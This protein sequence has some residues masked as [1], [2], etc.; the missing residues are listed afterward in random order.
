VEVLRLR[1]ACPIPVGHRVAVEF[2]YLAA[3][4][5]S[6]PLVRCPHEPI[7]LDEDTGIRYAPA[8]ALHPSGDAQARELAELLEAPSH[9]LEL[10]R[11]LYG[12]VVACTVVSL[13]VNT[14]HPIH[15]RL[16]IE[17]DAVAPPYR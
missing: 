11:T 16:V 8:W 2:F 3:K 1:F 12:R 4:R 5:A 14:R 9:T 6:G 13:P 17:P 7:V 15:T 10:E